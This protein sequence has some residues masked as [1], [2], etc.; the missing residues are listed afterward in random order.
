MDAYKD[1]QRFDALTGYTV[2]FKY[3]QAHIYTLRA[4]FTSPQPCSVHVQADLPTLIHPTDATPPVL[5]R[6][7]STV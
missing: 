5:F 6:M 7:F 1:T 4:G 3:T 2:T